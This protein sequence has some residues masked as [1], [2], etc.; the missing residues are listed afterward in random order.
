MQ[1]EAKIS[2][3]TESCRAFQSSFTNRWTMASFAVIAYWRLMIS[4]FEIG[5]QLPSHLLDDRIRKLRRLC[6]STNI[7]RSHIP[8]AVNVQHRGLN[9]VSG[10]A[11][12]EVSEH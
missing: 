12:V 5:Y 8:F 2:S 3:A 1:C 10:S 4:T 7:T 9:L 11:F 6:G